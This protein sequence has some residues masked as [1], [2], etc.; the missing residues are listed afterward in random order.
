MIG[1]KPYLGNKVNRKVQGV[2]QS[3]TAAKPRHQEEEKND[4]T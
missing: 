4:K 1:I 2:P 3:Q